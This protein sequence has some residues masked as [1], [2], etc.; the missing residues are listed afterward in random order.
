MQSLNCCCVINRN[1]FY[2][3]IVELKCQYQEYACDPCAQY[4]VFEVSPQ[5]FLFLKD[6]VIFLDIKD[7]LKENTIIEDS[8]RKIT[9]T[10]LIKG[11]VFKCK[12]RSDIFTRKDTYKVKV[13]E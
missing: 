4:L 13:I 10:L 11:K 2:D 7:Y 12:Y 8:T 5:E 6:K 1:S 3:G 9:D